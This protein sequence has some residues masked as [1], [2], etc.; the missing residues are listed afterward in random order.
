MVKTDEIIDKL[1]L[2]ELQFLRIINLSC[3][4][5]YKYLKE[6]GII[7]PY[8]ISATDADIELLPLS[9]HMVDLIKK[10]QMESR[11]F[12]KNKNDI[13]IRGLITSLYIDHF[14]TLPPSI[15]VKTLAGVRA[16]CDMAEFLEEKYNH[17]FVVS[18]LNRESKAKGRIIYDNLDEF[19]EI[20]TS[21]LQS[22]GTDC[23]YSFKNSKNG[24]MNLDERFIKIMKLYST[25]DE[26][27]TKN[28]ET[29]LRRLIYF[30]QDYK[31][32]K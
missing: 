21:E 25:L 12:Y 14:I 24:R 11:D 6:N 18:D 3:F 27:H 17:P 8:Y 29:P 9:Q 7:N 31:D 16:Y 30:P 1:T 23:I 20:I 15:K 4:M 13:G 22:S 10:K 28:F 32:L 5:A 26:L 2:E 19:Q